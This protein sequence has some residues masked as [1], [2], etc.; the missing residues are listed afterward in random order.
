MDYFYQN[1]KLMLG[2]CLE[3]L[4]EVDT[5]SVDLI[6]TDP[7]YNISRRNNYAS[8]GRTSIDFGDWDHDADILSYISECARILKK[9][10]SFIV[11]GDWKKLGLIVEEAQKHGFIEKDILRYEKTNPMPRNRDRRYVSD[12]EY[13]IWFTK[14][15]AK[16]IFNRL[17]DKYQRPKFESCIAHGN[18]PTEKPVKILEELVR[19]HS[20]D[21]G[22]VL[23]CFMGSGSTGVACKNL[24][25][26]FIGIEQNENYYNT[27]VKRI[28]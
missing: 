6:L 18:H 19:I 14:A 26:R 21:G 4:K 16:W 17:D 27:A 22:T 13:A 3:G 15:G 7:P 10:G 12:A 25:R 24:N 23:D 20:N 2:N 11:F 9:D 8:M 28:A 1:N 5:A